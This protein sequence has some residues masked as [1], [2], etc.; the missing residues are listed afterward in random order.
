MTNSYSNTPSQES[1]IVILYKNFCKRLLLIGTAW[2]KRAGLRKAVWLH[3]CFQT[4]LLF[5]AA[6]VT[7]SEGARSWILMG[8]S[9]FR[10]K[11]V[12]WCFWNHFCLSSGAPSFTTLPTIPNME[13]K[14]SVSSVSK[15]TFQR[16]FH[17]H[18]RCVLYCSITP[19]ISSYRALI[20]SEN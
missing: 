8:I 15:T 19:S 20:D 6:R 2:I 11:G 17:S 16:S 7:V 13:F 3:D 5:C 1:S 14:D 9:T 18:L 10:W 4:L 12:C